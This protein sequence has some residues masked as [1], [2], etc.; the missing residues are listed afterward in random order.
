[1]IKDA[2]KKLLDRFAEKIADHISIPVVL[3]T[4]ALFG[5]LYFFI[6]IGQAA[7]AALIFLGVIGSANIMYR[8]RNAQFCK[9]IRE[10]ELRRTN[11]M[12]AFLKIA[13]TVYHDRVKPVTDEVELHGIVFK[14]VCWDKP[15]PASTIGGPFCPKCRKRVSYRL[16][17]V[18][19]WLT[20]YE[21]A[22]GFRKI[23]RHTPDRLYDMLANY[24]HLSM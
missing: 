6:E 23:S 18:F 3:L 15:C 24:L 4:L 2:I 11:N 7:A 19:P 22:C 5:W 20:I 13:E 1:M 8:N 21:C 12:E 9:T 17:P 14:H 16:L 10:L